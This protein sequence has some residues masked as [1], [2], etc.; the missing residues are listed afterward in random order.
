MEDHKI[1][2]YRHFKGKEYRVLHFA[3]HSENEEEFVVYVS[4]YGE[5][6]IWIRPL[7]MFFEEIEKDGIKISRFTWIRF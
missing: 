4:L 2:I 1:G 7:C 5:G 6:G 3:K